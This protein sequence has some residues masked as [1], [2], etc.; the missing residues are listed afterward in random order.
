M[1]CAIKRFHSQFRTES[2]LLEMGTTSL[3]L[4]HS[5]RTKKFR[6]GA[7]LP[8]TGIVPICASGEPVDSNDHVRPHVNYRYHSGG[9]FPGCL[10]DSDGNQCHR[11]AQRGAR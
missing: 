11:V 10:Y 1:T 5:Y 7:T 6:G 8:G 9:V 2:P 3:G 4:R